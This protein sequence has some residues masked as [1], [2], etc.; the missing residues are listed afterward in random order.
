MA[1]RIVKSQKPVEVRAGGSYPG[2]LYTCP[3]LGV[4]EPEQFDNAADAYKTVV[5]R[6]NSRE[7]KTEAS[8]L[9]SGEDTS[10]HMK[11]AGEMRFDVVEDPVSQECLCVEII[12]SYNNYYNDEYYTTGE[13]QFIFGPFDS[14]ESRQRFIGAFAEYHC[15]ELDE[16]DGE[17]ARQHPYWPTE[18]ELEYERVVGIRPVNATVCMSEPA[19]VSGPVVA[20][21]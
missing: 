7:Y 21:R 12:N 11:G 17:Q 6:V 2:N 20:R 16:E 8:G 14:E 13:E 5:D 1:Y 4:I 19:F 10:H 15:N 3:A 9:A 18:D